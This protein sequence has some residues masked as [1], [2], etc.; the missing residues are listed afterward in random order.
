MRSQALAAYEVAPILA[1]NATEFDTA[2]A[3]H[4]ELVELKASGSLARRVQD[5]EEESAA[6]SSSSGGGANEALPPWESSPWGDCH[7]YQQCIPG[8]M[9]RTVVCPAPPCMSPRPKWVASC[10]CPAPPC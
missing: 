7:C 5:E 8:Y 6:A 1:A 4:A 10:V 3:A 2:D 9:R